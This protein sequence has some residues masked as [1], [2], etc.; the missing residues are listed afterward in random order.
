MSDDYKNVVLIPTFSTLG[1]KYLRAYDDTLRVIDDNNNVLVIML[2]LDAAFDAADHDI[3]LYRE[4]QTSNL[5]T[6]GTTFNWFKSY[7]SG[8][9]TK[10]RNKQMWPLLAF[11]L[12]GLISGINFPVHYGDVIM[13]AIVSQITSLRIV[14]ST[15]YWDVNDVQ[16][17]SKLVFTA[18]VWTGA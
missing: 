5:S 16:N 2:K 6:Y 4:G 18:G 9:P 12:G 3:L 13:G 1:K 7:L 8:K 10:E 15:V 17:R 14:Y 11:Q